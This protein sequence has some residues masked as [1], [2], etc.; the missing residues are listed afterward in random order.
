LYSSGEYNEE[1]EIEEHIEECDV[2][3]Q[4]EEF[5]RKLESLSKESTGVKRKMKPNIS[6]DWLRELRQRLKGTST[7]DNSIERQ[8]N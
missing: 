6:N 4:V 8:S 2:E 7:T 3:R 5:R 1:A